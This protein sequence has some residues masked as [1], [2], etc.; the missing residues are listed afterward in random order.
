MPWLLDLG[1]DPSAGRALFAPSAGRAP[2][3]AGHRGRVGLAHRP[4]LGPPEPLGHRAAGKRER[5]AAG[6][7]GGP[8]GRAAPR[9]RGTGAVRVRVLGVRQ[10]TVGARRTR[11]SYG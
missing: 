11:G 7:G 9:R 4:V 2:T 1:V 3:A 5:P 8:E 10:S 6:P